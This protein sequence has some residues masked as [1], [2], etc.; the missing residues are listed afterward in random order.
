MYDETLALTGIGAVTIGSM[1]VDLWWI[2]V[3]GVALMAVGVA[4]TR[5]RGLARSKQDPR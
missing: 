2:G 5:I 3:G 1:F 4:F